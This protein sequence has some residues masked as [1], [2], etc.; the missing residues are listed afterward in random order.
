MSVTAE[1][2][3]CSEPRSILRG[4]FEKFVDS[5]YYAES[6]ISHG[7]RSELNS[8]FDLE[9]VDRWNPI[10]TSAIQF[11]SHPMR[12]LGFSNQEKWAPRQEI[13][14]WSTVCS[15]FSRNGCSVVRSAS[16]ARGG[17]SKKRPSP[18]LHKVPTRSNKVSPRTFQT[19]FIYTTIFQ[20]IHFTLKMEAA[21]SSEPLVSYHYTTRR[22]DIEHLDLKFRFLSI[23]MPVALALLTRL[24]LWGTRSPVNFTEVPLTL[25]SG[26]RFS[27]N[28]NVIISNTGSYVNI[29]KQYRNVASCNHC[30]WAVRKVGRQCTTSPAQPS[31]GVTTCDT[32]GKAA[33]HAMK[34]YW[35]SGGIAPRILN[36]SISLRCVVSFTLP[37]ALTPGK[38]SPV[39]IG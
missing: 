38:E 32:K 35:E 17:T 19:S 21:W 13:S 25:P 14:K 10:R 8:V 36:L 34:T 37:A 1:I 26:L 20:Q 11:R 6:E 16:L 4:P 5:P 29:T 27:S 22:H 12:L 33:H 28:A 24:V 18:H 23:D 2:F 39:P 7:G 31:N 9:K 15:T 3:E 30:S